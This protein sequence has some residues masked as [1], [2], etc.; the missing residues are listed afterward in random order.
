M[1]HQSNLN[2]ES[3]N[4]DRVILEM[5][6]VEVVTREMQLKFELQYDNP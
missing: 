3:A 4:S 6:V 2:G 5:E 1:C